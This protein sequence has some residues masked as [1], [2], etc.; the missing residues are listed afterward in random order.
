[1][2]KEARDETIAASACRQGVDA[3]VV[4]R[5]KDSI[6]RLQS[7]ALA[8]QSKIGEANKA[9]RALRASTD[10]QHYHARQCEKTREESEALYLACFRQIAESTLDPRL[11]KAIEKDAKQLAADRAMMHAGEML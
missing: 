5:W 4:K 1:V 9:L 3:A 6:A 11:Y 7:E 2:R 8:A 10:R